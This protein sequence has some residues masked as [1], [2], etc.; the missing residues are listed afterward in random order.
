MYFDRFDIV[1]AYYAWLCN[2]HEGLGSYKYMRL[3]KVQEYFTPG[4]VWYGYAS[5]TEN[6]QAIYRNLC[7]REKVC[8]CNEEGSR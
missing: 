4:V 8:D 6:G 7:D 5:L 3:C 1:Q 2:H